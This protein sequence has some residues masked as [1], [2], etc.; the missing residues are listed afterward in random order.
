MRSII[1]ENSD[2]DVSA[3]TSHPRD[4][5]LDERTSRRTERAAEARK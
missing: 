3:R 4:Y 5:N 2:I 1:K